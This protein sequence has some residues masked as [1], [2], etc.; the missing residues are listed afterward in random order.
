MPHLPAMSTPTDPADHGL[1][2][3]PAD[4]VSLSDYERHA[5]ARMTASAW[6]YLQGGAG[7]EHTVQANAQAWQALHLVPRVLRRTAGGHTRTQLF[8]RTLAHPLIVAPVAYQHLMHPEGEL[9][10]ALAAA[11]QEA[12]FVLSTQSS[13]RLEDIGDAIAADD[14]RGPLW[15]QLYLQ[16]DRGF[17]KALVHR[18]EAAGFEAIVLTVDAP[19]SGV[20]DRE[21][22]AGFCLPPGVSAV[23]LQGMTPPPTA[24]VPAHGSA[25]FDGLLHH[26]PTWD[27]IAWLRAQTRLPIVLKGV[28]HAD[29]ARQA[30]GLGVQGLIVSNHGGRTLDTVL[31]TARALPRIADAVGADM[32]VL[33]DGGIRRGT[34]VLKALALG[35]RAVLIGRPCMHALAT[36]GALGVAHGIRLLRDELEAAMA[37]TG[38]ATL[39]DIHPGLI[40][41]D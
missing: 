27:D 21:R 24:E 33:V 18:A 29:D 22:R 12:G 19:T 16:P 25:L 13:T 26:A 10:T 20:R 8:G 17:T 30:L 35:A 28:L 2:A 31:P 5:Q 38:C 32:P 40:D 3:I 11:A 9:D 7:D 6:A 34:D 14:L 4:T 39:S 37:L 1:Q 36:A 41:R 15:M 23:N